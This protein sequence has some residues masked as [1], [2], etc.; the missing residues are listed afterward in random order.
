MEEEEQAVRAELVLDSI[1]TKRE[2][3]IWLRLEKRVRIQ[4]IMVEDTEVGIIEEVVDITEDQEEAHRTL[5]T[6]AITEAEVEGLL[7]EQLL[8]PPKDYR[9][10]AS[11]LSETVMH[12]RF[13]LSSAQVC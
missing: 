8:L 6:A 3:E 13:V 12:A 10:S 11:A 4:T 5:D 1:E 7:E 2:V 9:S